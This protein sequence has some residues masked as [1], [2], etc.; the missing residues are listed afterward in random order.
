[1]TGLSYGMR[2]ACLLPII[3]F[4]VCA[5]AAARAA[6]PDPFPTPRNSEPADRGSPMSATEAAATI[7]LPPGFRATLA[8]AEPDVQNPI[9]M[10]W[11]PRGRLWVAENFTYAERCSDSTCRSV[12]A[13]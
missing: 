5:T 3:C 4:V 1:M 12:T 10:A 6:S 9:A 13:S 2:T 11:D 7:S 8:A